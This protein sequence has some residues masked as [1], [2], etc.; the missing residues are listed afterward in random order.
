MII[1]MK[2]IITCVFPVYQWHTINAS[3]KTPS[4]LTR[5]AT[6]LTPHTLAPHGDGVVLSDP[7]SPHVLKWSSSE[8]YNVEV[9]AGDGTPGNKY[10]LASSC[11]RFQPSGICSEFSKV[12]NLCD[13]QAGCI[14]VFTTLKNFAEFLRRIGELFSAFFIHEKHQAYDLCDLETAIRGVSR[15]L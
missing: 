9:F 15:Y 3:F 2:G 8:K 5:S 6:C 10:G 4:P 7:D 13:T 12:V 1:Y 11:R 14:K